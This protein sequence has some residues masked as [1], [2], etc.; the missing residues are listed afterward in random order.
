MG[1]RVKRCGLDASGSM[2]LVSCC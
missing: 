2:E 1:N